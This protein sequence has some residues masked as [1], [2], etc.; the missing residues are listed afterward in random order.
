MAGRVASNGAS[1]S[2]QFTQCT[3]MPAACTAA[4][5]YPPSSRSAS[6]SR[7][8]VAAAACVHCSAN[9]ARSAAVRT[10]VGAGPDSW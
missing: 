1:I 9:V 7:R 6:V 3:P 2:V 5:T 4:R 10:I 8:V